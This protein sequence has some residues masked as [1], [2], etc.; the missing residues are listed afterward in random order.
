MCKDVKYNI[1]IKNEITER[2]EQLIIFRNKEKLNLMKDE[3]FIE[4]FIDWT[5]K[6]IPKKFK[7]LTFACLDYKNNKSI[8]I[9]FIVS[10]T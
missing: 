7:L 2:S 9:C 10:N 5:F 4:Y 1:K 3:K 8:L 6:I